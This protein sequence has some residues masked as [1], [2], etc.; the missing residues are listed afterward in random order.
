[1]E[2]IDELWHRGTDGELL[3]PEGWNRFSGY[4]TDPTPFPGNKAI[5]IVSNYWGP[6]GAIQIRGN[7]AEVL[8]GFVDCGG[9][10]SQLRYTRPRPTRALKTGMSFRLVLVSSHEKR[11]GVWGPDKTTIEEKDVTLPGAWRIEGSPGL[12]W[13][14]V[15]TAIRY[16]LE[17]RDKTADAAIKKNADQTLAILMRLH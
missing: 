7:T 4:Y 12:P 11:R 9:M 15:N 5:S 13:T 6:P 3:T 1:M 16:V 10:D 14:T 17:M 2:L 8:V